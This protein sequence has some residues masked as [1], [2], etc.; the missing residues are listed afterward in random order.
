MKQKIFEMFEKEIKIEMGCMSFW[1][2]KSA[3]WLNLAT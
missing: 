3:A 2:Y 1:T